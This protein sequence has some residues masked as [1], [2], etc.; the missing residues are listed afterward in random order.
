MKARKSMWYQNTMFCDLSSSQ[1]TITYPCTARTHLCTRTGVLWTRG[2]C[3]PL[4][5]SILSCLRQVSFWTQSSSTVKIDWVASSRLACLCLPSESHRPALL[6]LAS[7][8]LNRAPHACPVCTSATKPPPATCFI[9][10]YLTRKCFVLC[11]LR[12]YFHSPF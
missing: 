1:I 10:K 4:L 9:I 8:K 5:L 7:G 11:N 6:H 3:S 12:Q 2:W